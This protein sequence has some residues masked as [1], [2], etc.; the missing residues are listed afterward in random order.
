MSEQ[1]RGLTVGDIMTRPVLTAVSSDTVAE[2][3][4]RMHERRVGSVVVV[5][6]TRPV[7]ILTERDLVRFAAG[8]ADARTALVGEHMSP[9][10]DTVEQSEEVID[11]FRRLAAH[12]YRHIPVVAGG[13]LIGIL[14]MR[15]LV[16]K[17]SRGPAVP[18]HGAF[19]PSAAVEALP[20]VETDVQRTLLSLLEVGR[21]TVAAI[22]VPGGPEVTYRA[23]R[24]HVAEMAATLAALGI[25]RGDRVAIV[26]PPGPEAIVSVLAAAVAGTAAPLNP[27]YTEDEFR[28]YFDDVSA[29]AL[30]V[31]PGA[32][33]AA[34]RAW[35]AD[36]PIIEASLDGR[37]LR[38][39]ST[40]APGSRRDADPPGPDDVALVLHSSGTT[41]LPKRAPLRQRNLVAS[42]YNTVATY[43][44][45]PVDVSLCA[46]PLFHV[47]GLVGGVL[48]TFASGGTVVVSGRFN[49][50]AFRRIVRAHRVTWYSA[51]PT[52]HQLILARGREGDRAGTRT[53]RFVR[54][55]SAKLAEATLLGL[56]EVLGVPVLEA[57]GMTEASIRS[58][59]TPCRRRPGS[60][61]RSAGG[62]AFAS[63]SW[64][65]RAGS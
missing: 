6:G 62:S 44:L 22:V 3:A 25:R 28:F 56:E 46:M 55:A 47:H 9:D 38:L 63:A 48:S 1:I 39:D 32:M 18:A 14:S 36:A 40:P 30:I 29:R 20:P 19:S 34:R 41:G 11:A 10:P 35:R 4:A 64:T 49:P 42:A 27:V 37:R 26:L 57:Y 2:A 45:S 5:D 65:P 54:S 8:A 61:D 50:L 51:V 31:P 52:V 43:G 21:A 23:L 58:P 16:M 24:R 17:L 59:P 13:E 33:E 53:L 15:D 12:G 7:G 60:R